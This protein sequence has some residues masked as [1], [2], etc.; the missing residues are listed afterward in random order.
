MLNDGVSE[1]TANVEG[2]SEAGR[3]R[4]T[5]RERIST[6]SSDPSVFPP[7]MIERLWAYLTIKRLLQKVKMA[8]N[9]TIS[10]TATTRALDLSLRVRPFLKKSFA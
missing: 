8:D 5:E 10:A 1:L 2:V 3:F 9:V 4:L 7:E 6:S